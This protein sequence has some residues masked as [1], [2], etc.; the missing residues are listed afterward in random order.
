MKIE[1]RFTL[2]A[3]PD[4]SELAFVEEAVSISGNT[5][6]TRH[7]LTPDVNPLHKIAALAIWHGD[8]MAFGLGAPDKTRGQ[9]SVARFSFNIV[10]SDRGAFIETTAAVDDEVRI[11][12]RLPLENTAEGFRR[13]AELAL[14]EA[15]GFGAFIEKKNSAN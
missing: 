10:S 14:K 5:R 15:A 12:D 2:H 4:G 13:V 11:I 9:G 6:T 8:R 7:T 3:F 1:H